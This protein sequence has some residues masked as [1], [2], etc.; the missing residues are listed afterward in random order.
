MDLP[1][2]G[3]KLGSPT[4]QMNSLPT[5]LWGKPDHKL[6]SLKWHKFIFS[7]FSWNFRQR[8]TES[9]AWVS[10][11]WNQSDRWGC[12]LVWGLA[13]SSE[14]IQDGKFLGVVGLR[15]LVFLLAVG[16]DQNWAGS[17]GAPVLRSLSVFPFLSSKE[18]VQTVLI[19]EGRG[20]R[21]EG[22]T[23]KKQ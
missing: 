10:P 5:K 21:E 8:L 9:S 15:V 17:C 12:N 11:G 16:W 19:R 4:L 1:D 13:A 20:W 18:H 22:S 7:R 3:I 14:F 23:A 6:S 2:P